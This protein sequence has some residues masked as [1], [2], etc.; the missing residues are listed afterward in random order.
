M[1]LKIASSAQAQAITDLRKR[2]YQKGSKTHLK[3]DRFLEWNTDDENALILY[4]ANENG[5]PISSFRL[6]IAFHKEQIEGLFDIR[7]HQNL[8]YPVLLLDKLTTDPDYRR[9]GLSA[10][11]RYFILKSAVKSDIQNIA[12]TINDG[13]SRKA[14]LL[15]L[16][17]RLDK[18]DLSHRINASYQNETDV[19]FGHL[20]QH[21]FQ[22]A[23]QIALQNLISPWSD[24]SLAAD[25]HLMIADFLRVKVEV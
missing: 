4:I 2:A 8:K 12:F 15:E 23:S 13:V 10:A 7:L 17:F 20:A 22:T 5:I 24:F 9:R 11:M 25:I 21:Q 1:K 18:A 14:H 16:G 6:S 19:L 3:D